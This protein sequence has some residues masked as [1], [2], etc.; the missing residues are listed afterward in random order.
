MLLPHLH[1]IAIKVTLVIPV[2][3]SLWFRRWPPVK[4]SKRH[5]VGRILPGGYC[6]DGE[7]YFDRPVNVTA[8]T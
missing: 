4:A 3:H 2:G 6:P 7:L 8:V 1:A 5:A